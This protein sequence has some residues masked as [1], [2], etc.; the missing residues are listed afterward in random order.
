M[1]PSMLLLAVVGLA[2]VGS[3]D[4]EIPGPGTWLAFLGLLAAS[5]FFSSTETAIFG[6]QPIDREALKDRGSAGRVVNLLRGRPRRLLATI[7][8]G[9]EVVNVSISS[10][11]AAIV[12][13]LMPDREWLNI[14]LVLPVLVLFGEVLPKNLALRFG[15][16]WALT[17]AHPIHFIYLVVTPVR[18]LFMWFV[19]HFIKLFGIHAGNRPEG[20]DEEEIRT[21]VDQGEAQGAIQPVEKEMI[22]AVFDFGDLP[23]S[24]LMTPR[25]DMVMLDLFSSEA[26]VLATVREHAVS[27]VPVFVNDRDNVIGILMAKDLLRYLGQPFPTPRQLQKVLHPPFFVPTYKAAT[28][29][30]SDMRRRKEHMAIVVDEHGSLAGLVTLDDL[31]DELTGQVED[32]TDVDI[33]DDVREEPGGVLVMKASVDIDACARR[34]E[35][36][37]PEGDYTTLG[38]FILSRLGDLPAT[39]QVLEWEDL[40]FEVAGVTSRRITDVR[41][42]RRAP[43]PPVSEEAP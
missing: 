27:R 32:E 29:L 15:R 43:E 25:P 22:H 1:T 9:N 17:V 38:G 24:R 20:L 36:D 6:L 21:L 3:S 16:P 12:A 40:I 18:W 5:A 13:C 30:L 2:T 33:V 35:R 7:L 10:L 8:M 42:T 23:V 34:L 31:L 41:I 28:D 19:D 11:A 26:E 14:V 37:L 39:G 4:G